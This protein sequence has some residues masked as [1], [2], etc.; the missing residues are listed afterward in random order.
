MAIRNILKDEDPTLRKKSRVVENIDTRI[1]TLMDD[2]V[3]TMYAADGVGLAAPQVGV[4]KRIIVVDVGD[5]IIELIN[6]ELIDSWGEQIDTEG[7][8]SIPGVTGDVSRPQGVKVRGLNRK[9]E[10]IEIEGTDLLARALCHEIDHLDG[11]LFTDR[12]I[13]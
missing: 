12:V 2:M 7:C 5:G 3:D 10:S 6:P 11:V 13:D 9:G 4:L 1:V 8:L